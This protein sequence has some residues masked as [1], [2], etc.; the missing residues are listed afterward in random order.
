M[1]MTTDEYK[2]WCDA[3]S[4]TNSAISDLKKHRSKNYKWMGTELRNFF[5]QFGDV[6]N[7]HINKDASEITIR[8]VGEVDL[9][10]SLMAT[11]PFSFTIDVDDFDIIFVLKP[12]IT[13]E[14]EII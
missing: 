3:V 1:S 13:P 6:L 9:D 2:K 8:M 5:S 10:A 14:E 11:L 7:V 4:N 12:S